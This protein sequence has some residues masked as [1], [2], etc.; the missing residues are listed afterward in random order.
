MPDP[1]G[2]MTPGELLNQLTRGQSPAPRYDNQQ[3]G[4]PFDIPW[5]S[6]SPKVSEALRAMNA[7]GISLYSPSSILLY[8]VITNQTAIVEA[9]QMLM[10]L[11]GELTD[12]KDNEEEEISEPKPEPKRRPR[13]RRTGSSVAR[14]K[15]IKR[16]S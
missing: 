1:N 5:E 16:S 6:L 10:N 4:N 7:R 2:L 15:R 12:A 9:V 3:T 13:T 8:Q 11:V 14:P